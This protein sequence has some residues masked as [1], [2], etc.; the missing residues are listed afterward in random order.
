MR[1]SNEFKNIFPPAVQIMAYS[2]F[3]A[4]NLRYPIIWTAGGKTFLNSV[5]YLTKY[6][7]A[8]L[9]P[10]YLSNSQSY[11]FLKFTSHRISKISLNQSMFRIRR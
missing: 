1:Y 8:F 11:A 6:L 9:V 5:E 7:L 2:K 10:N 3:W 4:Q